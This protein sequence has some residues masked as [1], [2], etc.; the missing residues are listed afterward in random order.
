M[1]NDI[2]ERTTTNDR[3]SGGLL[4]QEELHHAR[5]L[6][7]SV[8]LGAAMGAALGGDRPHRHLGRH[9]NRGLH[10]IGGAWNGD[11]QRKSAKYGHRNLNR[12]RCFP[13]CCDRTIAHANINVSVGIAVCAILVGTGG[14]RVPARTTISERRTTTTIDQQLTN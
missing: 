11:R 4:V 7:L 3:F 14:L 9:W 10:R 2:D 6:G 12:G 5:S 13:G 8:A 1:A